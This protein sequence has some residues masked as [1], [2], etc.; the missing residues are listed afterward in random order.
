[1]NGSFTFGSPKKEPF[2][3][4]QPITK[5]FIFNRFGKMF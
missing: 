1:M 3:R 4:E 5:M 2:I